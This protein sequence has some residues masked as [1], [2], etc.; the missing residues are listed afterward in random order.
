M[1]FF[2]SLIATPAVFEMGDRVRLPGNRE[3]FL[4]HEVA[5]RGRAFILCHYIPLQ[6]L[7]IDRIVPSCILPTELEL[8]DE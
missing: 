5:Y 6:G 8:R 7:C 4:A 1:S 2:Q 3:A